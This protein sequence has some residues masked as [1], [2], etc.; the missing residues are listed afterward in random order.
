MI[1]ERRT[2][3]AWEPESLGNLLC[4]IEVACYFTQ[5]GGLR[6]PEQLYVTGW[7]PIDPRS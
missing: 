2:F 1:F 4:A 5:E 6:K 3:A 7:P